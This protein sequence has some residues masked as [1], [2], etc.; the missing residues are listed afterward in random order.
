MLA[1][2]TLLLRASLDLLLQEL[3]DVVDLGGNSLH[4]APRALAHQQGQQPHTLHEQAP[5][6]IN[7][8]LRPVVAAQLTE[9]P[10]PRY[11][12]NSTSAPSPCSWA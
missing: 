7:V 4:E 2:E 6:P 9:C 1:S 12:M 8:G 10:M 11:V 3:K 5:R